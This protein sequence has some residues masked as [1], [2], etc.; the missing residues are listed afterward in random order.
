[1]HCSGTILVLTKEM[2]AKSV[3][4]TKLGLQA[5]P[6]HHIGHQFAKHCQMS[7]WQNGATLG[8]AHMLCAFTT[9]IRQCWDWAGQIA[10]LSSMETSFLYG[11]F[12]NLLIYL[13][14]CTIAVR[15]AELVLVSMH[16]PGES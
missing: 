2:H 9:E 8:T 15:P 12:L 13:F 16:G 1:M 10:L 7:T 6:K 4:I 11:A 5:V 3:H 14:R